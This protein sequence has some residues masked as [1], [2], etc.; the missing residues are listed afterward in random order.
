MNA[1]GL[2][3]LY[4]RV[5][6]APDAIGRLRRFVLDLAVR[7]KLVEQHSADEPASKLLD[8]ITT[9]KMRKVSA[10]KNERRKSR[11]P[12]MAAPPFE[13]PRTWCWAP[14]GAVFQYDAGVKCDP[15]ALDSSA[16]L[17]DLQDIE[18]D[19]GRLLN[20][21]RMSERQPK[22]TKSRFST[23]DVLYGKLRP[24]LNKVL[25]ADEM[26]YSTTEIVALRPYLQLSSEY[27]A[28][29]LRRP[30]FV[31]Y[32]TRLGQG[33]KMPR[34]RTKD[35]AVAPFPLPPL[36]E[37]KR[38]AA[39][40][41]ELMALCDRLQ[42]TRTACEDTR[43]RLTAATYTRLTRTDEADMSA[44]RAHARFTLDVL[45]S[46][47]ARPDQLQQLRQTILDLA[48]R[49]QLAR[50]DA[51]D[52]PVSE[53]LRRV[54]KGMRQLARSK[55]RK[56]ATSLPP[57]DLDEAP[58]DLPPNWQWVYFGNIVEFSAGRTPPRRETA[59]WD[60][61][62][63]AW[64]SIADMVDGATVRSTRE[65]V[66]TA[67]RLD[68]FKGEP[69]PTGTMIMSFKLTIGKIAKLGVPAFHNEAIISIWPGV[70]E[71]DPFLFRLLPNLA[72]S[73]TAIGAV[74]GAT[75]NRQS[76][77]RIMIPL[78]PLPEQ[79]RIVAKVDELVALCDRIEAGLG[80]VRDTRSRLL[81]SLLQDALGPPGSGAGAW[82]ARIGASR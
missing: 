20:R 22:S 72:R 43:D 75:L 48:V 21:V 59:Y 4:D 47:T 6:D 74:K 13:L 42:K 7:G 51:T 76:L 64:V 81:E 77:S 11:H 68:V 71:L 60:V 73:V 82:L 35:A 40:V 31:D 18:K 17:L 27:C 2:L 15:A 1:D 16:W 12:E 29:A 50:Q 41:D 52:E 80:A 44:L 57:I 63:Y 26:G 24:Y 53:L 78:P 19:T 46:L 38:I 67:A 9:E 36:A 28:L 25:V 55:R 66:S 37:Q 23:G 61:G 5:A 32:V 49:G 3:A 56:K 33:T 39:K 65:S 45:P 10:G 79:R 54:E 58:F 69:E 70:A 14:L 8:R 30:D 62:D 34:L